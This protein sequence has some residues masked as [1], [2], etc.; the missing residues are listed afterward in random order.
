MSILVFFPVIMVFTATLYCIFI[1]DGEHIISILKL[2]QCVVPPS[3]SWWIVMI[4][5]TYIEDEGAE[6]VF[7]CG[8]SRKILGIGRNLFFIGLFVLLLLVS[9]SLF[10]VNN[11]IGFGEGVTFFSILIIQTF[12]YG[13][14]SY[15]LTF[16]TRNIIWTIAVIMI[17]MYINIWNGI[18]AVSR[19]FLIVFLFERDITIG[20]NWIKMVYILMLG[21][22]FM[23]NGQNL[24]SKI[25]VE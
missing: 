15:L 13:G 14:L 12:F 7:A 23:Y 3:V 19:Y 22:G 24:F 11:I 17:I 10:L 20:N 9:C 6:V 2:Y 5:H 4:F 21:I 8:Y 25:S 18:P 16:A 1:N